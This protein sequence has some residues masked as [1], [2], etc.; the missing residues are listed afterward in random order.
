MATTR[1]RARTIEK[2]K[3]LQLELDYPASARLELLRGETVVVK[4]GGHALS[5]GGLS[6]FAADVAYLVRA[7]V[8]VVVVHGG[9]PEISE[10]MQ[11]AGI[12]PTFVSGLRVT[13]AASL[14]IAEEV[15]SG[16]VNPEIVTALEKAGCKAVGISGRDGAFLRARYKKGRV[17]DASGR[18]TEVDLGFVGEIERIN[19]RLLALLQGGGYVPVITPIGV[20]ASGQPLNI[21]ADSVAG[22]VA[23]ALKAASCVFL[24]DVAG[25]LRDAKD[26]SS[27]IR[28]LRFREAA[29]LMESGVVTGGMIPKVGAC[30]DALSSGARE[31]RIADG[32]EPRALLNA[33]L[34]A[35]GVGSALSP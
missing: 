2:L 12:Q 13:D 9:G 27:L 4:Y 30:L 5:S 23:G 11:R 34:P 8:R 19:S 1:T 15:L 21:N 31:A 24:T 22:A 29:T 3:T 7:G 32:R 17:K 26:P 33:L 6:G 35:E 25:I 18:E 14:K 20:T 16:R 28:S 10:E